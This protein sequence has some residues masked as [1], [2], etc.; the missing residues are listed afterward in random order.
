MQITIPPLIC[1]LVFLAH[2]MA[3]M[4][5]VA[6]FSNP[7]V[8][9]KYI[10][11]V[12]FFIYPGTSNTV[13]KMLRCQTLNDGS[14]YLGEDKRIRCDSTEAVPIFLGSSHIT[15]QDARGLAI[16][17]IFVYPIGVPLL[18]ITVLYRNRRNLFNPNGPLDVWGEPTEPDEALEMK[19]GQ[20]YTAYD[21]KRWYWE[22][23][24]LGR[25]LILVGL[26]C[27]IMPDTPTQLAVGC[28][29]SLVF[30]TLYA[31]FSPYVHDDDDNLQLC[32]Q[33]RRMR[34][35]ACDAARQL[36]DPVP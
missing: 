30:I 34:R 18:F 17:M 19:Y 21:P 6:S 35:C 16:F 31:K 33:V 14:R 5:D 29:L 27:F 10:L 8:V 26:I 2:H 24:E 32:C 20:L 3:K 15:Y 25:K 28:I 23:I 11:F 22:V 13:L 9:P 36:G 12:L 1:T 7:A 4:L